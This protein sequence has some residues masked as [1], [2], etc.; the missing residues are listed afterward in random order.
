[1]VSPLKIMMRSLMKNRR[2]SELCTITREA[3]FGSITIS[4]H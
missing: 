4:Y 2:R 1:M 3:M